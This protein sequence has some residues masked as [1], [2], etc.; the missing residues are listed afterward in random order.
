MAVGTPNL[1]AKGASPFPVLVGRGVP[2]LPLPTSSILV[3]L[4]GPSF[5]AEPLDGSEQEKATYC[6]HK[7]RKILR[8]VSQW[9]LLYGRLLQ[10]DRSTTALLQVLGA[11][12]VPAGSP[13]HRCVTLS[14]VPPPGSSHRASPT[15]R[16]RTLGWGPWCRSRS[17]GG[18]ERES[19]GHLHPIMTRRHL[20][21]LGPCALGV[22]AD[23]SIP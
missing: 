10:G 8:L 11:R 19:H 9:V 12:G 17:G 21:P 16:A 4:T 1:Q 7:R 20:R 13:C 3:P 2:S 23:V 6:L 15:W 14:G 18:P 22:T 5:R